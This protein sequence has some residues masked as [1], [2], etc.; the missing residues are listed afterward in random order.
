MPIKHQTQPSFQ[1]ETSTHEPILTVEG[2]V[3]TYPSGRTALH[4]ISFNQTSGEKVALV[5]HNGSGKSTLL[6]NLIGILKGEG[7]IRIAGLDLTQENLPII[8]SKVGLVFQNPDDQL[9]SPTVFADVAFGPI[10]LGYSEEETTRRVD[11]ALSAVGMSDYSNRL[12]YHL[13]TGEKKR[14]SI[15]TVLSMDPEII[16]LDEPTAGL[17]PKAR[18][19]LINLLRDLPQGMLVATHDLLMVREL[20]PRT[21]ILHQGTVAADGP[22]ETIL[23]DSALLETHGLEMPI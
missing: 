23:A 4:G 1:I 20:F 12:S 17:D 10:H 18:R 2:L 16:V 6:L 3:F 5:G 8:R 9:F 14:I 11:S 21:I 15:A 19:A 13:S 7:K 22:T